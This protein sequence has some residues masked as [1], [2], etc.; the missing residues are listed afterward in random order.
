MKHRGVNKLYKSSGSA[1]SRRRL[2]AG[3]VTA[4]AG[5][6]V[7]ARADSD[8]KRGRILQR[9]L[10]DRHNY[11]V[12]APRGLR[13]DSPL[14][15]SVHGISRNARDHVEAFTRMADRYDAM[16]LAPVF[17]D[18]RYGDYQR[19]GR[20][21]R[22]SRADLA[23]QRLA[24]HVIFEWGL[25]SA[26]FYL[27]GHSGGAQFAH[28]YAMAYPQDVAAVGVSA[29]GWYTLPDPDLPYPYGI[30][31]TSDSYGL[32]LDPAEFL[33]V[34]AC[35][36]VGEDD[37][38]RDGAFNRSDK[39]DSSQGRNRIERAANWVEA[40]NRAAAGYGYKTRYTLHVLPDADHDFD[41]LVD[42]GL[43]RELFVCLFDGRPSPTSAQL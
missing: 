9:E 38:S 23:L 3:L 14:L 35:V 27:Y 1:L 18:Y 40:M 5:A 33:Q 34:P 22:G 20:R 10:D 32:T 16:I 37:R 25:A 24:S 41:E 12:Y 28:R 42:A 29:A 26:K 2:L 8:S 11:F 21:G 39:L 31:P 36:F 17:T 30:G 6:A 13:P 43:A 7:A 19:L 4:G 15:V